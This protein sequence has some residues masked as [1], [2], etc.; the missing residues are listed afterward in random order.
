MIED[1][2]LAVGQHQRGSRG[3]RWEMLG[4]K[5]KAKEASCS[6]LYNGVPNLF[7][8]VTSITSPE[9]HIS[10]QQYDNALSGSQVLKMVQVRLQ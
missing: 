9:V 5:L 1:P 7:R 6:E 3:L 10:L 4:S 2:D 8:V